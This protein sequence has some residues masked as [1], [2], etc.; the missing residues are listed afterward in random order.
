[1]SFD[2]FESSVELGTPIELYEFAQ[3]GK[4]WLYVSGATEVAFGLDVYKPF[5]SERA[6]IK[7]TDDLNQSTWGMDF[8]LGHEFAS[9][10]VGFA[11]DT[12]TIITIWRGHFGD[13][14]EE[15]VVQWK[16]RVVG[17]EVAGNRINVDCESIFTSMRRPGLRAKFEL[18]CRHTLYG[19]GC[20]VARGSHEYTGEI[21]TLTNGMIATTA[22]SV[23]RGQDYYTGGMVV[24]A[25]GE[26]RF[27]VEH[28]GGAIRVDRPMAELQVGAVLQ[29]YPGCDHLRETC[30]DK[31]GNLDNFGGFPFIPERNP[32]DGNAIY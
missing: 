30:R 31:F 26:S 6:K 18:G 3:G 15:F 16:G 19:R 4:R 10:F 9:Q 8:P 5:T 14:D 21:L 24:A 25:G 7:V 1:M 27:I 20:G 13:P 17:A 12:P 23:S 2:F 11:P 22:D 28:T 32:F 29:F